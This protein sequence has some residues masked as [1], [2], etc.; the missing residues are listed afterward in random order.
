MTAILTLGGSSGQ[1]EVFEV[2][3][4]ET[5]TI[6][7]SSSNDIAISDSE[8]SRNHA[9]VSN[10]VSGLLL[11]DLGSLNGTFLN[12]KR[13]SA[14]VTLS[15]GDLI[16]IGNSLLKVKSAGESEK[17]ELQ[18]TIESPLKTEKVTILLADVRGYKK[19]SKQLPA[20]RL[21]KLISAWFSDVTEIVL[22]N[23]GEVDKLLGDCVMAVWAGPE[24]ASHAKRA[25]KAAC[26]I[27]DSYSTFSN[28]EQLGKS[29]K[30]ECT[31][32][33]N[34]GEAHR[35]AVGSKEGRDFT[36][37]GDLV[38]KT[39]LIEEFASDRKLDFVVS[40]SSLPLIG[41][42]SEEISPIHNASNELS[43]GLVEISRFP[44]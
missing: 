28:R 19:L 23:G 33:L 38:N 43:L 21:A 39:F 15:E 34:S 12:K 32:V 31:L 14:P 13:I 20:P 22:R 25:Y 7:R 36:V 40:K 16:K 8:L 27:Q 26:E 37:L 1:E 2:A 11:S 17:E 3:E 41:D 30:W 29:L 4:G 9:V 10:S 18:Q 35:G 42:I 5:L 24:D 6:G 44:D